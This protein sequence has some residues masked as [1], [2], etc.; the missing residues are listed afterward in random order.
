MLIS[1]KFSMGFMIM[2]VYIVCVLMDYISIMNYEF[3][4]V[5]PRVSLWVGLIR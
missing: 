2:G 1:D 5:N 4:V 3:L